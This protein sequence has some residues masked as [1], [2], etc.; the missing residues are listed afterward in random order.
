M[1]PAGI[2]LKARK[3]LPKDVL[4]IASGIPVPSNTSTEPMEW[5]IKLVTRP[6]ETVDNTA[7]S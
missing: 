3:F 7:A 4:I 5:R 2:Q 6:A 1:A